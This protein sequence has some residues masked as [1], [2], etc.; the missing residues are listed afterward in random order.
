M[1]ERVKLCCSTMVHLYSEPGSPS[2]K[3]PSPEPLDVLNPCTSAELRSA[4]HLH[5]SCDI[6]G[7]GVMQEACRRSFVD[8]SSVRVLALQVLS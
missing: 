5:G 6:T 1:L 3:P 4:L 7:G 2:P 8:L